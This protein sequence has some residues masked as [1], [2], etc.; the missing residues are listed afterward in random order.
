MGKRALQATFPTL[1]A[2]VQVSAAPGKFAGRI[3]LHTINRADNTDHCPLGQN[4]PAAHTCPLGY[5]LDTLDGFLFRHLR[6][7]YKFV[8]PVLAETSFTTFMFLAADHF[9]KFLVEL[10][11]DALLL[12]LLA[13][14]L[15]II[16]FAF[17]S[18]SLEDLRLHREEII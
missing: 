8:L 17:R 9:A 6:S 10:K 1:A 13:L 18:G 3:N 4:F 14:L 16:I 7:Q 11:L 15:S 5:M 12:T 2:V